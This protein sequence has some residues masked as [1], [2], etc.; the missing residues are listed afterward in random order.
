MPSKSHALFNFI[1]NL[2]P[3]RCRGVL[4]FQPRLVAEEVVV[5]LVEYR[6]YLIS[7][8]ND[9]LFWCFMAAPSHSDLPILSRASFS[10]RE[11]ALIDAKKHI[12]HLLGA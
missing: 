5:D 12:D 3:D 8:S 2:E 6:E 1:H 9:A 7:L 10:S 4:F 11:D